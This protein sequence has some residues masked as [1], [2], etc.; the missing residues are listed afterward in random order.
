[1]ARGYRGANRSR[2]SIHN[3]EYPGRWS[4]GP[5]STVPLRAGAVSTT[6]HT[7][8]APFPVG[9]KVLRKARGRGS[10][11]RLHPIDSLAI[12]DRALACAQAGA[13]LVSP[14][15][16]LPLGGQPLTHRGFRRT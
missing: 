1:M 10:T 2:L 12:R 9:N 4:Q 13:R 3:L 16:T 11:R 8:E 14:L 6:K 7:P 5:S 15:E